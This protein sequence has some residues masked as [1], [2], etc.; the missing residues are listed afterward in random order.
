MTDIDPV[1]LS[2]AINR[3][4]F[5]APQ[6][7]GVGVLLPRDVAASTF[8]GPVPTLQEF[9][10]NTRLRQNKHG[11]KLACRKGLWAVESVSL[12]D[13]ADEAWGYFIQYWRDGEYE[14]GE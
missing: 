12:L 9:F 10:D 3:M 14:D 8:A 5:R 4:V 2:K 11:Y 13:L 7:S 6:R 1:A